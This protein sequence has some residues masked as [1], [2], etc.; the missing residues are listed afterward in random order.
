[1][2]P[3]RAEVRLKN[4]NRDAITLSRL[5]RS[6]ELTAIYVPDPEDE[7]VRDLTRAREDARIAERKAKQRL[8]SFLLRND[9]VYSGKKKWTKPH[10]NWLSDLK[11]KHPVQQ[12][13]FL[14]YLDAVHEC[15]QRI[16]RINEQIHQVASEW[17]WAPTVKSL[18][19]LRGG[20]F[21]FEDG[22]FLMMTE[23]INIISHMVTHAYK[24]NCQTNGKYNYSGNP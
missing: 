12:I 13:V 4:D 1:M 14:E 19:S 3:K 15:S 9:F 24:G 22:S 20:I 11:M 17:R 10:L 23:Q 16:I 8:N 6:G 21:T 5:L 7:A 18:Q 2:I